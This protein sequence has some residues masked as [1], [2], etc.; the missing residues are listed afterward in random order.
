MKEK[1]MSRKAVAFYLF[2]AGLGLGATTATAQDVSVDYDKQADF[3]R[4]ATYAWVEGRP[5]ADSLADKHIVDA[6]DGALAARG[7]RKVQDGP[8]CYVRYQASVRPLKRLQAWD[9]RGPFRGGMVTVEVESVQEGT[10]VVD[11]LDAGGRQLI[12]RSVARNT[13]SNDPAKNEKRLAKSV[14]KMF[15]ELPTASAKS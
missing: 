10:L 11:I 13:V 6:I 9:A 3:S 7:L 12:W 14:N 2:V 4:C 5:A 8:G 1:S 15:R